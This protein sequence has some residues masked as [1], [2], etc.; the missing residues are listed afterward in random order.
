MTFPKLLLLTALLAQ[1]EPVPLI[2]PVSPMPSFS[3][4]TIRPI[5]P[6]EE[7]RLGSIQADSYHAAAD[8]MQHVLSYAFGLGY[9]QELEG[10]PSWIQTKRF[11][12]LGKLDDEE[13]SAFRK[14]SRDD[15]DEQM[16]LM[17][18]SM[19]KER[20]HLSY[21]FETR[22]MP[23]YR[24]QIAKN[25]FQCPSDTTSPSA[26]ADPV[27][28]RFRWSAPPPPPPPPPGWQPPSP[29]EM[30]KL[31]QTL[32]LRTKGWPFWLL[33]AVLGHQPELN[34]K[35]VID[36]TGLDGAYACDMQWSREGS[37]GTGQY[38]F[39]AIQDQLGLKLTPSKGKVEVLVV[40]S[41]DQPS[42]N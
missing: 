22:E 10:G 1:Q 28:P 33:V 20:F 3:V 26:I 12:I 5:K 24:L 30:K 27:R 7:D 21:H 39:Q 35:P 40:D 31:E 25:G 15:R 29:A 37:E 8:L 41:I 13:A 2:H 17:V 38:L 36:E 42:E 32:H 4:V 16:R 14:L 18:Q 34:G 19:L 9:E 23:V 6:G 11:D